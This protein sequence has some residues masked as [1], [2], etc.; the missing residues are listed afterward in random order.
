MNVQLYAY[1]SPLPIFPAGKSQIYVDKCF[2]KIDI[3]CSSLLVNT[4]HNRPKKRPIEMLE[5]A[6]RH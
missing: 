1:V 4:V 2:K 5:I 3:L 6:L